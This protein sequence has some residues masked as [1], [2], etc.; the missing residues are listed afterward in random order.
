MSDLFTETWTV[1]FDSLYQCHQLDSATERGI[2]TFWS[3][4]ND[5]AQ[6]T[7]ASAAPDLYRDSKAL[8]QS[9]IDDEIE[10]TENV[11]DAITKLLHTFGKARGEKS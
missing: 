4:D 10:I 11:K 7:L 5:E 9:L 2:A 1:S 8:I 6:A 3:N